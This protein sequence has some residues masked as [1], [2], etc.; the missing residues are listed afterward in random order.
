MKKFI[1]SLIVNILSIPV[2][3]YTC[4][5]EGICYNILNNKAIV[6][7]RNANEDKY[8]GKITIPEKIEY[9]NKEYEVTSID[10]SAFESSGI[11]SITV[12]PSVT[13]IQENA[14]KDCIILTE[15]NLPNTLAI[16]KERAFQGCTALE[17]INL[18]E[19]LN[20]IQI[21]L[22]ENCTALKEISIP[23]SVKHIYSWAFSSCKS[24]TE[25][26]VPKTLSTIHNGVFDWCY[27]LESLIIEDSNEPLSLG[28][29]RVTTNDFEQGLSLFFFCPLKKLYLGRNLIY[30]STLQYGYSPFYEL[31]LNDVT[32]GDEMTEIPAFLFWK[33]SVITSITLPKKLKTINSSAFAET[34]LT[35][36]EVPENV[37][38]IGPGVFYKTP[39][40]QVTLPNSL[41]SIGSGTF[42]ECSG[43]QSINLPNSL[44][45]IGSDAF[46][47]CSRLQSLSIPN[48]VT[49]IGMN[50]I[51]GC[52]DLKNIIFEDG[53]NELTF[54]KNDN[55]VL[56]GVTI[57]SIHIGRDLIF[58]S[59]ANFNNTPFFGTNKVTKVTF[60]D[61][62]KT[63]PNSLFLNQ[64]QLK[65]LELPKSLETISD[66]AFRGCIALEELILPP[67]TSYIGYNAFTDCES[68]KAL[69]FPASVKM[70][71][72]ST[73]TGC[74]SLSNIVFEDG[75]SELIMEN[76]YS[77][78]AVAL[79]HDC[80]LSEI[81]IGRDIKIN[82]NSSVSPI[83]GQLNLKNVKIGHK[84][85]KIPQRLFQDFKTLNRV[86]LSDNNQEIPNNGALTFIML[87]N[88]IQYIEDYAFAGCQ[89]LSEIHLPTAMKKLGK[90]VFDNCSSLLSIEI[91]GSVES[92]GFSAFNG[93]TS[94]S[95]VNF[96]DSEFEISLGYNEETKG[97][98]F[99]DSELSN[100]YI[101][102]NIIYDQGISPIYGQQKLK[103]IVFG[104]SF[105]VVPESFFKGFGGL[106]TVTYAKSDSENNNS[107]R[108]QQYVE[109]LILP[110]SVKT[111][112]SSAFS[113]CQNLVSVSLPAGLQYIGENAFGDCKS[114]NMI[115]LP[116]NL[117]ALKYEAFKNCASLASIILPE[118]LDTIGY[119]VFTGCVSLSDVTFK[120]NAKDLNVE[121]DKTNTNTSLFKDCNLISV[122]LGRNFS[123]SVYLK[124]ESSPFYNQAKLKTVTIG[125]QLTA[126]RSYLFYGCQQL[127]SVVIP[128]NV[129]SIGTNTFADCSL[130]KSLRLE[131][132]DTIL[133]IDDSFTDLPIETL[134]LGRNISYENKKSP[135]V[136]NESLCYVTIGDKVN[137]IPDWLFAYCS[138]IKSISLPLGIDE[139]G[140]YSFYGCTSL[141]SIDVPETVTVIGDYGFYYCTSLS[142]F[143][144]TNALTKI[145]D[146]AFSGC[147]SLTD[148]YIP[149][150]LERIGYHAFEACNNLKSVN[151][152]SLVK[153]PDIISV[154]SYSTSGISDLLKVFSN[155]HNIY[156]KGKQINE[157]VVNKDL[158]KNG[159]LAYA[160]VTS[161]IIS[162]E[163][164]EL[165]IVSFEN[166]SA[167]SFVVQRSEEP[168]NSR[169]RSLNKAQIENFYLYRPLKTTKDNNT[170]GPLIKSIDNLIISKD[171]SSLSSYCF[172][173]TQIKN[174][175]IQTDFLSMGS[176]SFKSSSIE[177]IICLSS[178]PPV[179]AS[180][181]QSAFNKHTSNVYVPQEYLQT[182]QAT[183]PW[184]KF[185]NLIPMVESQS[186][187]IV[188]EIENEIKIGDQL[189]LSIASLTRAG[190]DTDIIWYSSDPE[191][192]KVENGLISAMK[193]GAVEIYAMKGNGEYARKSFN[194][195]EPDNNFMIELNYNK[196]TIMVGESVKLEA[197]IT[198]EDF[199]Y[200]LIWSSSASSIAQVDTEGRVTGIS[201]GSAIINA[202]CGEVSASCEITVLE[203]SGIESLLGSPEN[204]I[205]IY[206]IDGILRKKDCKVEDLKTL[207]KGI[208][209][210]VSGKD[211]YKIS[212]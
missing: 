69:S 203:D 77:S 58:S 130:L 6:T 142:S 201:K 29:S 103:E 96:E 68:L 86:L 22:F 152:E 31:G 38:E 43:L 140:S 146:Y 133:N 126:L 50:F 127:E 88:S 163:V 45:S 122:Y 158:N 210:I 2:F 32:L 100:L 4:R 129:V 168:L 171:C 170:Y 160:D 207:N 49:S 145:G 66:Y 186:M 175:L 105:N 16:I 165:G 162:P 185:K 42:Y 15:V 78:E 106:K 154:Y 181:S 125:N 182:Y 137:S 156:E 26:T 113:N 157:L 93:C 25:F 83:Y 148:I 59:K 187:E 3:A 183:T 94:L 20:A 73:F 205:S 108:S 184:S 169:V 211:R 178:R 147:K 41:L 159:L 155:N 109:N 144:F 52:K 79:F 70:I 97:G 74:H 19:A 21:G 136:N 199:N 190:E 123:Y 179:D 128:S 51:S 174:L 36:V 61:G 28:A 212:I 17:K 104:G 167:K 117:V 82:V 102:R 116:E 92:I 84:V 132:S 1:L 153:V 67:N 111:I 198:P 131:D 81:Y 121:F 115:D 110:K 10:V 139:I 57:E 89:N 138:A 33:C 55:G 54:E 107:T 60:G 63:I 11:T 135:F 193:S 200:E 24:L 151:F 40:Q 48:S 76:G 191:I 23:P 177:N 166:V 27:A 173:E 71:R 150:N 7:S 195:S 39:L 98:L 114:L 176:Y 164:S 12:P 124:E 206:S 120:D 143:P 14:F 34:R 101:G 118:K 30:N 119:N 9:L 180:S 141:L 56:N 134:H 208:Y 47:G 192:V 112:N 64:D 44:L 18:P 196:K 189:T 5:Y 72:A 35:S 209:I 13:L 161:I 65:I 85:T 46:G 62:V 172:Q 188:S 95:S 99:S 87:P 149:E 202:T 197:T 8:Y 75:D 53:E 37:T 91:P 204:S 194:V 90:S 80:P